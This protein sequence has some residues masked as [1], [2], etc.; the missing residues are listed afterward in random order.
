MEILETRRKKVAIRSYLKKLPKLLQSDYRKKPPYTPKQ[1]RSTI[2]RNGLDSAY[3]CF[4]L[5][6]YSPHDQFDQ[7][8][9]EIGESCDYEELR[10]V[11]ADW[12]FGGD[13]AF[14][15]TQPVSSS[16]GDSASFD[17]HDAVGY[18]GDGDG[19]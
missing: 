5:A 6:I 17:P 12:F 15:R 1:V 16:D 10:Q 9:E 7:Y 18:G 13:T 14:D 11:I 4:A 19:D 8:H 2:E 3:V